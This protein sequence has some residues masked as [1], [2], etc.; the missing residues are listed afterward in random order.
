MHGAVD[1]IVAIFQRHRGGAKPDNTAYQAV[2]VEDDDDGPR[3]R[4]N[5][6]GVQMR[7]ISSGK[8]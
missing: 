4:D 3:R 5:G 8:I 7:E 2:G 6:H 1:S